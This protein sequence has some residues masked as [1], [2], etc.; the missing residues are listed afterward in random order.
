VRS[1]T[2]AAAPPQARRRFE[3]FPLDGQKQSD[4]KSPLG[5]GRGGREDRRRCRL[6]KVE[7]VAILRPFSIVSPY[8]FTIICLLAFRVHR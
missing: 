8:F 7:M 5:G 3:R 6:Y 1:V 4:T 2:R